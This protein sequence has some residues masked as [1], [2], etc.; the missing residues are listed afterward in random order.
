MEGGDENGINR[1]T[2][3]RSVINKSYEVEEEEGMNWISILSVR[4]WDDLPLLH[5]IEK[6][7]CCRRYIR[8]CPMKK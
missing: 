1:N 6:R 7:A 8:R 4:E 3:G 5:I 2:E